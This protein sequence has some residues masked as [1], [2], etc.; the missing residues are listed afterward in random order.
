MCVCLLCYALL[1]AIYSLTCFCLCLFLIAGFCLC[2]IVIALLYFV[3]LFVSLMLVLLIVFG[4]VDCCYGAG[5]DLVFAVCLVCFAMR[6]FECCL[7]G[8][9]GLLVCLFVCLLISVLGVWVVVCLLGW[10]CI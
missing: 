9:V 10:C 8:D 6:L 2:T 5:F 3:A 7:L 1:L 4:F